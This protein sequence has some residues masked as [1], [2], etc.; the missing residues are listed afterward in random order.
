MDRRDKMKTIYLF[1]HGETDLNKNK[2]MQGSDVNSSLNES[3]KKQAK[4]LASKLHDKNIEHIYS[5]PLN[6]AL[7]TADFVANKLN[8]NISKI[9]NLR[10]ISFGDFSGIKIDELNKNIGIKNFYEDFSKTEKYDDFVFPNGES[11]FEV[12]ARFTSCVE[13]ILQNTKYAIIAIASHGIALKQF[14]YKYNSKY[15][16]KM[17]NC[18]VIRCIYEG[19]IRNVEII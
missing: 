5:S 6:R 7:E 2:I 14:Y 15:P 10:E 3:G 18:C 17:P 11:K 13:D 9:E 19:N 8:V 16:E 12:R 1:R 4:E